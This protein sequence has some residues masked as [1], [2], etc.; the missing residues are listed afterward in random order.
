MIEVLYN[1]L[2][3]EQFSVERRKLINF[4]LRSNTIGFKKS[5]RFFTQSK[6]GFDWGTDLSVSF[7]IGKSVYCGF[8][9][10]V[11]NWQLYYV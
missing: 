4:P 8:D 5:H 7:V 11:L 2:K 1:N 3:T 6:V 10:T 9:F